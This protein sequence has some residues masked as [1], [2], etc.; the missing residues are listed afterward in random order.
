MFPDAR[1]IHLIRNP[2]DN[3]LAAHLTDYLHSFE[4]DGPDTKDIL[5]SRSLSWKYHYDIVKASPKPEHWLEIT[6]EDF[7]LNQTGTL[8]RIEEFVDKKLVKIPVS[9]EPV[10][11]YKNKKVP[12][13]TF[14]G[15]YIAPLHKDT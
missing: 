13:Y 9:R 3:I 5:Y 12:Y 11:R 15:Q 4:I 6:F 10:G 1:Y 8:A 2:R 7:I 14:F